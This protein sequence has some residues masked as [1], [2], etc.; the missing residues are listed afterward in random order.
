MSE[1]AHQGVTTGCIWPIGYSVL[2]PWIQTSL[3]KNLKLFS[4]RVKELFEPIVLRRKGDWF[5]LVLKAFSQE[6]DLWI[7]LGDFKVKKCKIGKGNLYLAE[8]RI[9]RNEM[10]CAADNHN[11]MCHICAEEFLGSNCHYAVIDK[12]SNFHEIVPNFTY[13]QKSYYKYN[14][15]FFID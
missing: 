6:F 5:L 11:Y 1:A 7:T 12:I 4:I 8:N 3:S 13:S 9:S 2:L 14:W 10:W 15:H